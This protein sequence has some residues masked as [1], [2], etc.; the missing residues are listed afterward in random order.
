M[1]ITRR[2]PFP[3]GRSTGG[4]SISTRTAGCA[5]KRIRGGRVPERLRA[6]LGH[7]LLHGELRLQ[8]VERDRLAG[9]RE[10]PLQCRLPASLA[11][12]RRG[13][14]GPGD[15]QVLQGHLAARLV[16]V[17]PAGEP[18]DAECRLR[19]TGVAHRHGGAGRQPI[20][21]PAFDLRLIDRKRGGTACE[22]PGPPGVDRVGGLD[23]L[24]G[25]DGPMQR[26][27]ESEARIQE[28]P[29]QPADFS[30]HTVLPILHGFCHCQGSGELRSDQ[31]VVRLGVLAAGSA[32]NRIHM[33]ERPWPGTPHMIR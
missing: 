22:R 5:E 26:A 27:G 25:S 9:L 2:R 7:L 29:H 18:D 20:P 11:S 32:L 1:L 31:P 4:P 13:E 23:R 24:L 21:R 19:C 16:H 3:A 14:A 8:P 30:L 17:G 33:P 15:R 28:S 12:R 6:S 10:D